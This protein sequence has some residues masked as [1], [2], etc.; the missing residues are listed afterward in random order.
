MQA[1]A[2]GLSAAEGATIMR[3]G[4]DHARCE[5]RREFG[6]ELAPILFAG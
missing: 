1:P 5:Q 3:G 2:H 6:T 4:N